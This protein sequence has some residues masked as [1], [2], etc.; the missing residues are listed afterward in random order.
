M[1]LV[2]QNPEWNQQVQEL[3]RRRQVAESLRDILAILNSN[4]PLEQILQFI[5]QR[6]GPLL[7]ADAV[8]I[9]QLQ[10]DQ[11]LAIQSS[12]GLDMEYIEAATIPLG[13]AATGRAVHLQR[14]VNI[15][16]VLDFQ[17]EKNKA[18]RMMQQLL[19]KLGEHYRA[20]LAV[21]LIIR[22]EVYGAMTLYYIQPH[23]STQE[24]IDLAISF[25]DQVALAVENA[26]LRARAEQDAAIAERTRLARDLHDSVTQTLFSASLIAEVLPV[27]WKRDLTQ[28]Q[29]ALAEL[30]QLTRGALAEM[31][32]LLLELRPAALEES[33]I[34][35]L[36]KQLTDAVSGRI[37]V[38]IQLV[39]E[40]NA[41][42]TKPV[43]IAFYRIAQEAL[44]NIAKHA[45]ADQITVALH[46]QPPSRS[47][48]TP[49]CLRIIDNGCGFELADIASGHLG[50]EI[51]RERA[52][53]VGAV[54][55]IQSQTGCGTQVTI[56]WKPTEER[57]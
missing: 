50:L 49:A 21:P 46:C 39:I 37:R 4:L 34:E 51:M 30:H 38:P 28:G 16:D 2:N 33:R 31:R 53:A 14:P 45:E 54:V 12:I 9:Y 20:I 32:T 55:S 48:F 10:Q 18:N 35:D 22:N 36:L 7:G 41:V 27:V 24:E 8:A 26:R 47:G 15:P 40:G 6:A 56:E 1:R 17:D 5:V 42:L 43:Q 44:N 29:A 52:E 13:E 25:C 11:S 19:S 23:P 57:E 3:E